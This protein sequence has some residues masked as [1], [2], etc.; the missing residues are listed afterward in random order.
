MYY[1]NVINFQLGGTST[2][3]D[4]S[5][6]DMGNRSSTST[7]TA[8][9]G[10]IP[11]PTA[12][13]ALEVEALRPSRSC[14]ADIPLTS[15]TEEVEEEVEV[16]P[17]MAPISQQLLASAKGGPQQQSHSSRVSRFPFRHYFYLNKWILL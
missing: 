17:P 6:G 3:G 2:A 10:D 15:E 16:P 5:V 13:T 11:T 8:Q 1:Q 7:T 9:S 4:K 12:T 14:G